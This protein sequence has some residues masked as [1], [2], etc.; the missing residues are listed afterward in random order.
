MR[1]D[2]QICDTEIYNY[3]A[4]RRIAAPM[5]SGDVLIFDS[6]LPHGTP[7]NRTDSYRWAVQLHYRSVNSTPCSDE[8]RLA[9][10]GSEGKNVSC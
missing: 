1:R 9:A 8:E 10:F 3:L 7:K 4:N 5:R 6:K 2:W